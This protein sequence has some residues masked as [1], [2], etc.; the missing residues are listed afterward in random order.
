MEVTERGSA[1]GETTGREWVVVAEPVS[2]WGASGLLPQPPAPHLWQQPHPWAEAPAL[3]SSHHPLRSLALPTPLQVVPF[4]TSAY[5][6][7]Q[8]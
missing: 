2:G 4:F 5:L 3:S 1:R 8:A 7:H 6:N